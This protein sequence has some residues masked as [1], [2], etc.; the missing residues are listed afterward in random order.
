MDIS[1]PVASRLKKVALV[2]APNA[3]KTSLFNALTGLHQK[4]GNF[5][6]VT[7]ERKSAR[8]RLEDNTSVELVDLPGANSLYP[9]SED[10]SVTC[11]VLRNPLNPDHPD[12][13]VVVADATQLKRGLVLASQVLDL[14]F[15]AI[16]VLNMIDLV[17]REYVHH[18]THRLQA[19]LGIPVVPVSVRQEKGIGRLTKWLNKDIE[20]AHRPWVTVPPGFRPAIN[21][22]KEALPTNQD[23]LA[24][25]ALLD[26]GSF[27]NL[28]DSVTVQVRELAH[29]APKDLRLLISNELAVRNDRAAEIVEQVALKP[30]DY[31]GKL[32]SVLD[33]IFTHRIFGY[34]IFLGIL[35][36][37][38]QSIFAWAT[39]PMD[40][41]DAG[42]AWL[43]EALGSI[44][45]A[46]WLTDL[47]LNGILAG[48]GGIV[49]FVPQ[50]VFLFFFIALLE[51]TGY[52]SRVVF[53]MDRIMRPFGFSGKSVIPL[54]GGMACAIPSIMMTR[55]IPNKIERMITIAVIPL[56]SCSARIPVYTLLIAL[57][58]P[59]T[60]LLGLDVR[61]FYMT[62]L[63]I[64]GFLM[65]L[66][67]AF[68]LKTI[69][70]YK[71][72]GLFVM[73][74]PAYRMP[75]WRNVGITVY[76][77]ATSFVLGAGKIILG[78]SIVL[79]VLSSYGMPDKM[80]QIET[81]YAAKISQSNDPQS[82][83][84]LRL[85]QSKARLESSFAGE[86]GK[87]IEPAIRPLGF[88][89]KIGISIVTSFAARE[90]FVSTMS[91]L[92]GQE[93]PESVD[94][95]AQI[96]TRESLLTRMRAEINP[97][98]G[99]PVY[100][101]ATTLSLL[102]FY[103]F[104]MQCM[105]TLAVTR[106]EAGW[107]WTLLVLVYLTILSYGA[108]WITFTLASL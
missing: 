25:Q 31:P 32:T 36:L 46:G 50:I 8:I 67:V 21:T 55:S 87:F 44:L 22:L 80:K 11:D 48:F 77:Q 85:A 104:A 17:E 7:V 28:P 52:M 74:M 45:P 3:G 81:D 76:Q 16:L 20:P 63:Y 99:K 65:S 41:I 86:I 40:A 14:G 84:Q 53:L 1:T 98:T 35:L 94:G 2:G 37:I 27:R 107:K 10:E 12:L 23:Y 70:K 93:D 69:L 106:R 5:P 102:V 18:A 19:L 90:V 100:N 38:F 61:G 42:I 4:V 72:D 58:V 82:I 33:R 51:E 101:H 103:A 60:E 71:S 66:V 73:E 59:Q 62:G 15:P 64:L 49:V 24:F 105:S 79:W 34:A 92:Y 83:D 26:P 56:M 78:I 47:L 29:V 88:D 30:S 91:I 13:V 89:W 75:R 39:Y 108:S 43:Q 9:V 68:V 96:K 95:D 54:M 97:K 6:G 57:F